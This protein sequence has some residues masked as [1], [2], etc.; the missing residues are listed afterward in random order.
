MKILS[1]DTTNRDINIAL[2]YNGK[3]FSIEK[4]VQ[5]NDYESIVSLIRTILK[6]SKLNIKQI[7]YFGV[8]TGPGSFTGIRIGLSAVKALAY[9]MKKPLIG[10]NS[11][12]LIAETVKGEFSGILCVMQDARRNNIYSAVYNNCRGFSRIT[13]YLLG[14]VIQLLKRLRELNKKNSNVY[15]YGDMILH[16]KDDIRKYFP[17][18][19]M[20]PPKDGNSKSQA[21]ISLISDNLKQ[22]CNSFRLL[23]FYMYPKDCQVGKIKK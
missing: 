10:Y 19:T 1:I 6:K 18:S 9:S 15:F 5:T 21:M 7:D 13:P 11:L 8:C 2:S 14:D 17:H 3:V 23:P 16:Y 4:G 22:K 20:L 12:D